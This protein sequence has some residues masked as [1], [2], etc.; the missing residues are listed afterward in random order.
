MRLLFI[1]ILCFPSLYAIAQETPEKIFWEKDILTWEDFIGPQDPSSTYHANTSAGL[2][3]SWGVNSQNGVSALKYEVL[4]YFNPAGS[5]VDPESRTNEFL[6]DHEQL[7]FDITEL[8]ARKLRQKLAEVK[9]EQLGKDPRGALNK[10]YE[11]INKE[12][13]LMQQKYDRESNHSINA[14]G[15]YKWRNFVNDEMKKYEDFDSSKKELQ[16]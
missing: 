14:E 5:W 6:L 1:I 7:H 16:P 13:A 15:E 12:M 3:Y 4:S 2:S 10:L 8:H 11:N 9:I